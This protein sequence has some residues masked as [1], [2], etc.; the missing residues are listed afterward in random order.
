[1]MEGIPARSSMNV[2]AITFSRRGMRKTIVIAV[3]RPKTTAINSAMKEVWRV[4]R[5]IG[6]PPYLPD[7]VEPVNN[8]SGCEVHIFQEPEIRAQRNKPEI[9]T[10]RKLAT[11]RSAL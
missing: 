9:I 3:P 8:V 2:P 6:S 1:M 5:I 4:P 7:Q 11:L 10:K